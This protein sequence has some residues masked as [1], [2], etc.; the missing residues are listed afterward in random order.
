MM[1]KEY[2]TPALRVRPVAFEGNF[3]LSN[4]DPVDIQD[5]SWEED[6]L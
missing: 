2:L 3:M 4:V 5:G 6:G 1:K